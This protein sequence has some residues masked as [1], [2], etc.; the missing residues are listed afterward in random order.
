MG[1]EAG[2]DI[3]QRLEES[4]G[5]ESTAAEAEAGVQLSR[6]VW[7]GDGSHGTGRGNAGVK[8]K[9]DRLP[10]L[11]PMDRSIRLTTLLTDICRVYSNYTESVGLFIIAR[12]LQRC[13]AITFS[14][15]PAALF[16]HN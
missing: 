10:A 2:V 12:L 6:R 9:T 13:M 11:W 5:R 15:R 16:A 3:L 8:I 7:A 1:D 14:A 4:S